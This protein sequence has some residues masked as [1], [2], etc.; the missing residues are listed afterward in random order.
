M[1]KQRPLPDPEHFAVKVAWSDDDGCF[2]ASVPSLPG[3]LFDAPTAA[4][5]LKGVRPLIREVLEIRAERNAS[6]PEPDAVMADI[7]RLRPLLNLS[8]LAKESGVPRATLGTCLRRGTELAPE[9]ADAVRR[10]FRKLAI[11]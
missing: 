5:A 3:I 8:K 4:G 2:Y 10:A 9:Q 6:I 7:R 11:A 1:K